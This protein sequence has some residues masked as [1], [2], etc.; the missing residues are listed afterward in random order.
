MNWGVKND[1]NSCSA[2]SKIEE[3]WRK[4]MKDVGKFW[5]LMG[6]LIYLT[7]VRRDL[8]ILLELFVS[9]W[10]SHN[11][12]FKCHK[13][14]LHYVKGASEYGFSYK[15]SQ[16]FLLSGFRDVDWA[17]DSILSMERLLFPSYEKFDVIN[18]TN[19]TVWFIIFLCKYARQK[20]K[21][22]YRKVGYLSIRANSCF[23]NLIAFHVFT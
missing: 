18:L 3:R 9:L 10:K 15:K 19:P 17:R 6:S 4:L 7:I 8:H 23:Y 22:N 2:L 21:K 1:V 14:D 13:E 20:E 16:S 12:P 5:Q 11:S